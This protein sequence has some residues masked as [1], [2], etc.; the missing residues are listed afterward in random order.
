MNDNIDYFAILKDF[1]KEDIEEVTHSVDYC[2]NCQ[3]DSIQNIKGEYICT[4]CSVTYGPV[5]DSTQEWRSFADDSR[6]ADP[7]R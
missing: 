3:Q 4:L 7:N 6:N 2:K 1:N 5:I